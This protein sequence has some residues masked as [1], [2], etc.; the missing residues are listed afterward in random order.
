MSPNLFT[1]CLQFSI[2]LVEW[3]GDIVSEEPLAEGGGG[4]GEINY[5]YFISDYI[6]L[7]MMYSTRRQFYE[8]ATIAQLSSVFLC[9]FRHCLC[10]KFKHRELVC[11][12]WQ[13]CGAGAWGQNSGEGA[14]HLEIMHSLLLHVAIINVA[15]RFTFPLFLYFSPLQLMR[16][17]S[18]TRTRKLLLYVTG[19][20]Y[21]V[22]WFKNTKWRHATIFGE[23][24]AP[25]LH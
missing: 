5:I 20:K 22:E 15:H 9:I 21:T 1:T 16:S 12:K 11:V 10:K 13:P 6:I 14:L 4:K 19:T 25:C 24:N 2:T 7:Y 3:E 18:V 8:K 23:N 17:S